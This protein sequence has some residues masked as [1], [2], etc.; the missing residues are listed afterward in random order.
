MK[1]TIKLIDGSALLE[2]FNDD[3]LHTK[4][5]MYKAVAEA[6]A[7][8]ELSTERETVDCDIVG[9]FNITSSSD[10]G[11]ISSVLIRNGYG[12]DVVAVKSPSTEITNIN[13]YNM[14]VFKADKDEV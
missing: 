5:D 2:K 12:V 9:I 1:K 10:V 11:Y 13:H 6:P 3:S 14:V 4:S 7:V 8:A